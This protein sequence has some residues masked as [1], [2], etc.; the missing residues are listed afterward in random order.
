MCQTNTG[1]ASP[2]AATTAR[3]GRRLRSQ[4][5]RRGRASRAS[6]SWNVARAAITAV[7]GNMLPNGSP[8]TATIEAG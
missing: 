3:Q 2:L 5:S 8:W 4:A 7:V 6:P 1:M